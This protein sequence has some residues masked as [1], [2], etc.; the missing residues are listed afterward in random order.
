[1]LN[2]VKTYTRAFIKPLGEG[3]FTSNRETRNFAGEGERVYWA[4]GIIT[5]NNLDHLTLF[6]C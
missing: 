2:L 6:L 3:G 1:M 5:S 4:M